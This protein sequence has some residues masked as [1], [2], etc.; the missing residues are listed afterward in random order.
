[1]ADKNINNNTSHVVQLSQSHAYVQPR[2]VTTPDIKLASYAKEDDANQWFQMFCAF[3]DLKGWN[4]T[5]KALSFPFYVKD[6]DWF[7]PLGQHNRTEWTSVSK[8]FLDNFALS[9]AEC[10]ARLQ[11]LLQRKQ[12]P[13]ELVTD[14]LHEMQKQSNILGRSESQLLEA[15]IQGLKPA[16]KRQVIMMDCRTFSE[17]KNSACLV[18]TAETCTTDNVATMQVASLNQQ[19]PPQQRYQPQRPRQQY[20]VK[21]LQ[22]VSAPKCT[23]CGYNTHP[24]GKTCPAMGKSCNRCTKMNHFGSVCKSK[25]TLYNA[26]SSQGQ[27]TKE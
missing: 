1:M 13:S 10:Y 15:A 14:F 20:Q 17:L 21:R 12:Q 27:Q 8:A 9:R 19:P 16:N 22:G 23:R 11:K 4:D 7:H 3:A 6:L 2:S 18:E 25:N 24:H 26:P 5:T